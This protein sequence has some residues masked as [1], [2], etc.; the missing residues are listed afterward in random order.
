MVG[1]I[2]NAL[3]RWC[4]G[5]A[6]IT[7][8][9]VGLGVGMLLFSTG[10]AALWWTNTESFCASSCHEMSHNANE[11]RDTIHDKNRTGVRA[12]CSDCH[13]PKDPIPLYVRKMGAVNDLWGHFVTGSINTPEKFEAKRY[14]LAKRVW[15]YMQDNDSRECRYCH[16]DKKMDPD[17]QSDKAKAR[18]VKA[19]KEGLTCIDCH[20]G[21][22]HQEPE[23][24]PG[25]QEL[26]Q[27]RLAKR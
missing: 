16:N 20:F 22:A 27:E 24:G 6:S 5:K 13:V 4:S 17:R 1:K 12:T 11:H 14:E 26:K 10:S 18:H 23:G 19:Q 21:I 2:R 25:P 9:L 15:T 8:L 7:V 3:G